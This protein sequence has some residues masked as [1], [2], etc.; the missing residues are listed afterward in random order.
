MRLLV[1]PGS[2]CPQMRRRPE[3]VSVEL[4]V[5]L[6]G[7]ILAVPPRCWSTTGSSGSLLMAAAG[8]VYLVWF[9]LLGR[10]LLQL[11]PRPEN[12]GH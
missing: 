3:V 1:M 10:R 8:P 5:G 6:R 4:K 7:P 12:T 2:S 9:A 11:G